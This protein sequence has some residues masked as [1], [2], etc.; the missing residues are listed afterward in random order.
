MPDGHPSAVRFPPHSSLQQDIHP[1]D[2]PTQSEIKDG[3][4]EARHRG[5]RRRERL[6]SVDRHRPRDTAIQSCTSISSLHVPVTRHSSQCTFLQMIYT[7]GNPHTACYGQRPEDAHAA[8]R[9]AAATP[10]SDDT[11]C[12]NN[13]RKSGRQ[14]SC[15]QQTAPTQCVK[16]RC[17]HASAS[18]TLRRSVVSYRGS[19][20]SAKTFASPTHRQS[21]VDQF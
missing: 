19:S 9:P 21:P 8:D 18:G 7:A 3:A 15:R 5:G 20:S 14:M 2:N 6:P 10:H 4:G 11:H 17:H 13:N 16:Q 1:T 12:A